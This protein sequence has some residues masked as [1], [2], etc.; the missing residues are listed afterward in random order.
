M[1]RIAIIGGGISGLALAYRLEQLLPTVEITLLEQRDR[2]GGTI[3]T[4]RREGFQVEAGPNGFLDNNPATFNLCRDLGLGDH[5]VPA[6]ETARRNRFL[7]LDGQLRKLPSGPLSFLFSGLFSWRAKWALLREKARPPRQESGDESIDAFA[8]RRVGDEIADTLVDAFV[9]GIHAGDP[10][11]LSIQAA[12]PRMAE[13][14]RSHG[15][16]VRGMS[17]AR[18][19]KRAE[20]RSRGE[21]PPGPL[22]MWSFRGGLRVLV[23]SL[24]DRL[25]RPPVTGVSV[26]RLLRFSP[27]SRWEIQAEGRDRWEA[28]AVVLACPAYQQAVLLQDLDATLAATIGEIAYNRIAVV[29]LGFRKADMRN[30]LDGFGYL[31]PG[32]SKR[33][34]LGVQWCSSIYPDRAPTDHVLLR[35]MCG[36]WHR[37]EMV[38]WDEA[39]LIQA[40]RG[41]LRQSLGI[42]A[43]PV[44]H[45]LVRWERAIPQYHLGHLER[46]ARIEERRQQHAGLYLHGNAYR[47]VALNDCV[48]Q[49]GFLAEQIARQGS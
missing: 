48:E 22:R 1:K 23:D 15:S 44:F 43:E 16:V 5:L 2:V 18:K 28:D 24:R 41:E 14:E 29:A 42:E 17:A 11:L 34:V 47:G 10:K 7:M 12:F 27:E 39:Q 25:H 20:A 21:T 6:S 9:T 13:F 37:A 46:L 49:A 8:R 26:R 33:D 30:P 40:V 4:I 3:D 38:D 35:A 19:L 36:G 32:R 31:S 45:H